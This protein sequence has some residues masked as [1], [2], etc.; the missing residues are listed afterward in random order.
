[1]ICNDYSLSGLIFGPERIEMG[2]NK[3]QKGIRTPRPIQAD[4][5]NWPRSSEW[6]KVTSGG[7]GGAR[8]GVGWDRPLHGSAWQGRVG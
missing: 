3:Y 7:A 2:A 1:M 4:S 8:G 6:P 5:R